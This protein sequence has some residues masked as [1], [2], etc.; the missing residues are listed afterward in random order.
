MSRAL[1]LDK[2]G[3]LVVPESDIEDAI[4][5]LLAWD[6]WRVFK[7][8]WALTEAKREIGEVDSPDLLCVRYMGCSPGLAEIIW[9]EGK[10]LLGKASGMQKLWHDAERKRGATVLVAGVDFVASVDGFR[11]WYEASSLKRRVR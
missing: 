2:N 10:S 5:S 9:I 7:F 11:R 4:I 6:G 8:G 3:K 1:T